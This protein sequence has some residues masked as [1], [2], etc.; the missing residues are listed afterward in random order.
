[1]MIGSQRGEVYNI[2]CEL[3]SEGEP[4]MGE[5]EI[6]MGGGGLC[7]GGEEEKEG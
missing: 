6:G 2:V 1:M 3:T 4:I 5:V 7:K